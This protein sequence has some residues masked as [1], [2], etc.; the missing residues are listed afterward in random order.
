VLLQKKKD[1]KR[2]PI[3]YYSATLNEAERNYDIYDLELLA[4]V[5]ALRHWRH[6][7]AGSPHKIKI[8]S[9]HLN[10]T[11]WK[12]PQK[13]SRRVAREVLELMEYNFEIHHI[14]GTNNGRADALSRR[15][16]Y[17]RGDRDNEGVV[18]LPEESFVRMAITQLPEEHDQ[19]EVKLRPWVDP[20]KL[21]KIEGVWYRQGARVITGGVDDIRVIIKNHHDPL[22][23][24][25]PGIK[26]T[27]RIIER[28]YWWPRMLEHVT[29]YVKG[30]AEC[31]RHKVN[32]RPMRAPLVPITPTPD[33][34][35]F[36]TIALDFITK[37]PI[38]QGHDSILTVTDHDCTKASI[39]I[40]CSEEITAEG[41]AA[42]YV[43]HVFRRFGLPA[44]IISDRDPRFASKFTREVCR[45]LGIHQN[46]S[47]AYL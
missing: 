15:P 2:H 45:I 47:T 43:T 18:V 16:D 3:G 9:D 23:Y 41:T 12:S 27:A 13:I 1:G 35:P 37:L 40:P 32:N 24:G 4:I 14:K 29:E 10:L 17:D 33:A 34:K 5:K 46:I 22:M 19:D 7:L 11:H 25:H 38:S 44:K 21:K 8:F 30:C 31:Q 20:H 28:H 42:L 26:R 39:F 36:E 6:F